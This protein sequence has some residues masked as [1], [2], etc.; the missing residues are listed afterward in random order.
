MGDFGAI[1]MPFDCEGNTIFD[2]D[3]DRFN[4]CGRI[5]LCLHELDIL[6]KL[7]FHDLAVHIVE[8]CQEGEAC[9]VTKTGDWVALGCEEKCWDCCDEEVAKEGVSIM[10]QREFCEEGLVLLIVLGDFR[11]RSIILVGGKIERCLEDFKSDTADAAELVV[12]VIDGEGEMPMDSI[13]SS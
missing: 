13:S 5:P 1:I 9:H 2:L 6:L 8:V 12:V 10:T 3:E 4:F 7:L 11:V